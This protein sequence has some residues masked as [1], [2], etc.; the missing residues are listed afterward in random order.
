[1]ILLSLS[2]VIMNLLTLLFSIFDTFLFY[3]TWTIFTVLMEIIL[4][5]GENAINVFSVR[6]STLATISCTT[7]ASSLVLKHSI[8]IKV[9]ASLIKGARTPMFD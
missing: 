8:K 6:S 7:N 3:S 2:V 9:K 1:M 4:L 5:L